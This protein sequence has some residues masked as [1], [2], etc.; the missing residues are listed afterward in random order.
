MKALFYIS[1]LFV[2]LLFSCT[3]FGRN[4]TVK[5]K[6][7]NPITGTTYSNLK[8]QLVKSESLSLP[9]GFKEIKHTFTDENGNFEINASRISK[10]WVQI[11]SGSELYVLGWYQDGEYISDN[12]RA[13]AQK[14]ETMEADFHVVPYSYSKLIINNVNCQDSNDLL[15]LYR[16]NQFETLDGAFG[17]EHEGCAYWETN[18]YSEILMG[19][20]YYKW[21][22]TRGGITEVFYDTVF[23]SAGEQ[24]TYEINY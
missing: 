13:T 21:E 14:R 11:Q 22:V 19:N 17:W 8:V 12:F 20:Q 7:V 1:I 10:I 18:G 5:G 24:S 3:K 9:G 23:Y 15:V 4:I 16:Q 2:F 6:V